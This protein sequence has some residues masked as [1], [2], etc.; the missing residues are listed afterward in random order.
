MTYSQT[1]QFLYGLQQHGIKLGL[2]TIKALLGRV[3]DPQRRYPVVHIGGTNGKGSTSAMVAAIAQAAGHR[4]GLYTSPHLIDYRERMRVNGEM[5]S[6]SRVIALVEQ[7]RSAAAP[8]LAPTFFE[9][10]TAM[11]C[12]HFAEAGIDLAV[13]EVGLGG[14]FDATNVV[15]PAAT[16][17]TTIGLDHE[18]YLGSTLE[19]IAF[20][21]A[22][23]IKPGSPLVLGRVG[24][25]A[26]RVIEERA[27][28]VGAPVS[29]L[30]REFRTIGESTAAFTYEGPAGR[31][32]RLSCSLNG[33]FQLDNAACA[34][35][36]C[37][38]LRQAGIAISDSAIR[39]G[40]RDVAW[41]GRLEAAASSPTIIL[42]GA[43][44][45][46]AAEALA[47]YLAAWRARRPDGRVCLVMG[48]MRDKQPRGFFHPLRPYVDDVIMTQ[49]DLPRAMSGTDLRTALQDLAPSA[50]VAAAPADALA[51]ARQLVD[52]GDLICVAGSLMLVGEVKALL[53][54]C[55]LSPVRG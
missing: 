12:M 2:D 39:A 5:I 34:I 17:I 52:P 43:H 49:A 24:E 21:K 22:G 27:R 53:R 3:G 40:L 7:L 6:E 36:L 28:A 16:A 48:M 54:G 29:R 50:H 1:V 55:R 19:Q 4:V 41:E 37:G 20:E 45:P 38:V 18:Q 25:A 14:R 46:A 11:A 35:S 33:G 10:T 13:L 51:L 8:D 44:N 32:D 47:G 15:T 31:Y 26:G 42:D 23:I 9:F 30:D